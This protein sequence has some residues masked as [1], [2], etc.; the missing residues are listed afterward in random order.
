M[1]KPETKMKQ[2]FSHLT[3]TREALEAASIL[4]AARN[5]ADKSDPENIANIKLSIG[6]LGR[7][8][9]EISAIWENDINV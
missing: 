2:A 9:D 8:Y 5:D 6:H 7:A 3:K 1:K 4:Y